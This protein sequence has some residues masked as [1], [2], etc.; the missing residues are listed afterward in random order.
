MVN[1]W[2]FKPRKKKTK[3]LFSYNKINTIMQLQE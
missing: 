2:Y 1:D 3:Q